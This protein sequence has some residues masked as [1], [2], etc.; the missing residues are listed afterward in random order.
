MARVAGNPLRLALR[1]L[2]L[3]AVAALLALLIWRVAHRDDNAAARL[4][5]GENAVAPAFT[6]PRLDRD[7]QLSLSSLRGQ[8]VVINF[9]AS[10]C[11]P[12]KEEAPMLEQAWRSWRDRGVVFVGID[13]QDFTD[14]AKRFIRRYGLT[15]PTV[16]DKS[17]ATTSA[18]G[19]TGFPETFFVSADGRL[20]ARVTGALTREELDEKLRDAL[21][22]RS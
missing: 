18:Y 22:T 8:V 21:R 20:V 15:Y 13:A 16:R 14:K 10:W 1:V 3:G 7:G 12:C 5:R 9:W 6:L 19:L 2:A 17:D 4:E 11:A